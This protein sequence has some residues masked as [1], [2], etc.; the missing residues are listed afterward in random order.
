MATAGPEPENEQELRLA[1]AMR[2]GAS[3]A[4]WIGG[5]VA[6]VERLR[7]ALDDPENP[8]PWGSLARLAG[9]ESVS[10]DVLAGTSAGGLNAV[11]LSASVVYGM[12][13][14]AM[15]GTWVQL[16]DLEA[17]ARS[18][19]KLWS[20]RPPSLLE[21]DGYFRSEIKKALVEHIPRE[22]APGAAEPGDRAELLLTGTLLDPAREEHFDSRSYPINQQRHTAQFRFH[23]EGRPGE[24][25]SDFGSGKDVADTALRLAQ[26]ARTTSSYPFAFEP[27][28]VHSSPEAPPAGE[29]DMF[30]RFSEVSGAAKPFRVIDGGVLDNI[31]VTAAI[32][33]ASAASA[34]RPTDRWL[35][36]LNPDP[37]D[38]HVTASPGPLA[39]PVTSAALRAKMGQETLLSDIR[40]LDAHNAAVDRGRLRREGIYAE[41]RSAP[42]DQWRATLARQAA[43]VV[44][45]HAVVRAELD[46][47][48]VHK[49]LVEPPK[50]DRAN[51]LPP[52]VG[53][54]LAG[55]SA[56]ARTVLADRLAAGMG[57]RAGTAPERVFDDVRGL[58]AGV[59]ECLGWAQDI[60]RWASPEKL[61]EI[62]ACKAALY[63]LQVFG[64][65]LAAH[66]DRYWVNGARLEPIVNV[67]ELDGWVD[68]VLHRCSRLQH[69][70]PGP[71]RPLLGAALDGVEDG[72]RFQRPLAEFAAELVSIVDSSGVD[73]APHEAGHVD[74][75]A[76]AREALHRFAARLAAAAPV[77]THF[78]QPDELGYAVLERTDDHARVL[79]ELVVLT[80]PLDVGRAPGSSINF[81]RVASDQQTPLPFRAL[82]S[83]SASLR[84]ED[85]VRGSDV[86]HFGAF[87][88]AKWRANDWM[89]GR[90]DAATRLVD[91][92]LDPQRLPRHHSHASEVLDELREVVRTPAA[93]ELEGLDAEGTQRWRDFLAELWDGG[94]EAVRTE[95]EA[96]FEHPQG[97]HPLARSRELVTERLHW[98]IAAKEIPFVTSVRSGADPNH[99]S[100]PSAPTPQRL[101][102]VVRRYSVGRQRLASLGEVRTSGIFLRLGLIAHRALRPAGGGIPGW[103]ARWGLTA[104]KPLLLTVAYAVAAPLRGGLLAFLSTTAIVFTRGEGPCQQ[105]SCAPHLYEISGG[106]RD[107]GSSV[108]AVL[109]VACA[110]WFGWQLAGRISRGVFRWLGA[111]VITAALVAGAGWLWDSGFHLHAWGLGLV[112]V[113]V[114]A[115]ACAAYRPVGIL[116]AVVVTAL[117]FGLVLA[118]SLVLPGWHGDGWV[119]LF[120]VLAGYLQAFLLGVADVLKPRPRPGR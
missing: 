38:E 88:S 106:G 46:A 109:A 51:L 103:F 11:L 76:E 50:T 47:Q 81:L 35:L 9:Y 3:M 108:I 37:S 60:E 66:A 91:L 54:P 53:D 96:L 110:F 26:A 68:R 44:G 73:A 15:R 6:E 100:E 22:G 98:T 94:A 31:P 82:R 80:A 43:A 69:E 71:V 18:V 77:R 48:A 61:G 2:G 39:L 28:Q 72:S 97:E 49:L 40:A 7:R 115:L 1:L 89:W 113:V 33:A 118:C 114:T 99:R 90:L 107:L 21:G 17:M 111:L 86:G 32:R 120:A 55:W 112:A 30:G 74:A 83:D 16:A 119:V 67:A 42:Q 102:G 70:L 10:V 8:N 93:D 29:P 116:A 117:A 79:R 65:V 58:L 14:D 52:V 57:E 101:S 59:Q 13:F 84:T 24:P 62:G 63:R 4:V 20:P 105:G 45:G 87:L 92:L 23:H 56:Q 64:E 5:A 25:M 12:P 19:P 95:L 78:E 27:A 75:V 104:L 41:L 36:Y 85:K 34:D